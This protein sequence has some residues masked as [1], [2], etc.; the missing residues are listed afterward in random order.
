M[1][2]QIK[3]RVKIKNGKIV[4]PSWWQIK[5]RLLSYWWM[6][7][8]AIAD[9]L[10]WFARKHAIN[11]LCGDQIMS[12]FMQSDRIVHATAN[13]DLFQLACIKW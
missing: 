12:D 10:P 4:V 5:R 11:V 8:L 1:S 13:G 9:S 6:S 2:E 3:V 7:S